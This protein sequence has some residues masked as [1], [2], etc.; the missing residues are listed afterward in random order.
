[1]QQTGHAATLRGIGFRLRDVSATILV[2]LPSHY[3]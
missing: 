3:R 1:M 2:E